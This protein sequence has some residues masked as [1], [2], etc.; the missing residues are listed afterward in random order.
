MNMPNDGEQTVRLQA[1][2]WQAD[3]L[4]GFGAN[5]IRLNVAGQEILRTPPDLATLAASPFLYGTPVLMPPNRTADGRFT[6]AGQQWELPLTEP[7][8]GNHIHG[9]IYRAPY[10]IRRADN[11]C[12]VCDYT[13]PGDPYPFIFTITMTFT[14]N[15]AGLRQEIAIRNDGQ[16]PMPVVLALHTTFAKPASFRV[17]I[18]Q[19]W[20]TDS[21]FIPTGRM[22]ALTEQEQQYA[23]T[24][25]LEN[26]VISGFYTAAGHA[27]DIGDYRYA[28]SEC[29]DQ[30]VLFNGGQQDYLCVEPQI[31]PVNSLN[32]PG[33][34]PVLAA[35]ET[36]TAWTA[37]SRR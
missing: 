28:V 20:E 22:L 12:L 37:I 8:R 1:G 29:F 34:Y 5:L 21:R 13:Y 23:A 17:P 3:I 9:F 18:G 11:D 33:S 7:A 24:C 19:R 27:A 15:T 6:F 35:G 10:R 16:G 32:R 36:F 31:G 30:W 14:L 26:Q 2:N 4:P 25:I